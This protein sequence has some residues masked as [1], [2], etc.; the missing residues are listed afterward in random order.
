MA[1]M[2]FDDDY[3][4]LPWIRFRP[5]YVEIVEHYL[6]NKVYGK[7]LSADVLIECD[8]YEESWKKHFENTDE[9][10]LYFFTKLKRVGNGSRIQRNTTYGT[11]KSNNEKPIYRDQA[12]KDQIGSVRSL[13][14]VTKKGSKSVGRWVM[15]EYKL[16]GRLYN[17][18]YEDY[19][20]C[21][22]ERLKQQ[23]DKNLNEDTQ[24][25]EQFVKSFEQQKDGVTNTMIE[26]ETQLGRHQQD[27]LEQ[28]EDSFINEQSFE[29]T[30][31][32]Q[33]GM[34]EIETELDPH[35]VL[36][37]EELEALLGWDRLEQKEDGLKNE[38]I[39]NIEQSFETTAQLQDGMTEIETDQV[40]TNAVLTVEE[41]EALLSEPSED[42][43][44]PV[45]CDWALDTSSSTFMQ[46]MPYQTYYT[47]TTTICI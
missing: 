17:K 38:G 8:L 40:D 9:S 30:E 34:T 42:T 6:Y 39:Q 2:D 32:L 15:Y 13:T 16:K 46:S 18:E 1:L 44:F 23:E 31:Q 27:R 28:K 5:T 24:N 3:G 21:R 19:V 4:D 26:T 14:L 11:W 22:I 33:D 29:T 7:P 10:S 45:G 36:T 41:L 47:D 37:V 20:I 43:S 25:I 12:K 35:V